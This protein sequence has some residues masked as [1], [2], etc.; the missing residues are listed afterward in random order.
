MSTLSTP[1]TTLISV[2]QLQALQASGAPLK[3]FDCS[4]DLMKPEAA[5]RLY[6]E[7]HIAGAVQ[8]HLDRH[9][10]APKRGRRR[11]RRP[12]PPAPARGVCR[13]A[14]RHRLRQ[15]DAGRGL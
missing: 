1:Y 9:L 4:F 11:Q 13:V 10:S 2:D 7:V 14:A 3:V 6:A 5:D 15:H 8:A 12:P